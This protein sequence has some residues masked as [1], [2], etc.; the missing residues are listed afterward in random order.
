MIFVI[1]YKVIFQDICVRLTKICFL[2]I[3]YDQKNDHFY[4]LSYFFNFL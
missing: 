4:C 1:Y 3:C 2:K